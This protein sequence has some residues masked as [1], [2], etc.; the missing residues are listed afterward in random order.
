M[1]EGPEDNTPVEEDID[2]VKEEEVVQSPEDRILELEKELQYSAAEIVNTRQRM[3]R[4]KNEAL[5]Y[6]AASLAS[7]IIPIIDGLSKAIES[8]GDGKN[9]ESI[10]EG[11]KLILENLSSTLVNAG[12]EKIEIGEKKFDPTAMEAIASIPCPD[13][14]EPGK[15]V[16]VIEEGY[17]LHDRV[18]RAAKVIVYEG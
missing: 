9:P 8:S 18:L 6:G 12:I 7:K 15:I 11:V 4:D 13:G 10:V 1:P 5:K 17:K 16:Q 3:M 2:E 14:E